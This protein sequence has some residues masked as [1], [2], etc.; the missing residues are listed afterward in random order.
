M[1]NR[2]KKVNEL[3]VK[4]FV[5]RAMQ[6]IPWRLHAI[7]SR[8]LFKK[9]LKQKNNLMHEITGI[10]RGGMKEV[11]KT[12]VKLANQA[13]TIYYAYYVI[14]AP[15]RLAREV[16]EHW[17][18]EIKTTKKWYEKNFPNFINREHLITSNTNPYLIL[19]V[20]KW[21]DYDRETSQ[22]FTYIPTHKNELISKAKKDSKFSHQL[23]LLFTAII[24]AYEQ[25]K[26]CID[27]FNQTESNIL[28]DKNAKKLVI[29][30]LHTKFEYDK[31][32]KIRQK[33]IEETVEAIKEVLKSIQNN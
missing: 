3:G 24:K 17:A 20:Q 19:G 11:L 30:D 4:E 22:L 7:V 29:I 27:L 8:F 2:L 18:K 13:E 1:I 26:T 32:E 31:V 15:P 9:H 33:Q 21:I 25:D 5:I 12:S 16:G 23:K 28:W 14:P 10:V 6:N